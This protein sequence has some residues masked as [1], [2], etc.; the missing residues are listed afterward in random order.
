M[1]RPYFVH[2]QY[3]IV[4]TDIGHTRDLDYKQIAV[5]ECDAFRRGLECPENG[6]CV[7]ARDESTWKPIKR[8]D[9]LEKKK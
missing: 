5:I 4:R 6:K 7:V 9:F 3:L 2:C 8:K 1:I